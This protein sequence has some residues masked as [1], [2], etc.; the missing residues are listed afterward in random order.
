MEKQGLSGR[1]VTADNIGKIET[2][3]YEPHESFR[4]LKCHRKRQP[5]ILKA[6]I[7]HYQ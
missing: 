5:V 2:I 3:F 4:T 6:K 7:F 1:G